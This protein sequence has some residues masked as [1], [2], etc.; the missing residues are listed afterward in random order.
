MADPATIDRRST[1]TLAVSEAE[2][3]EM[4]RRAAAYAMLRGRP[5]SLAEYIRDAALGR[6]GGALPEAA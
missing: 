5:V 2:R 3:E 1:F 6:V 4:R